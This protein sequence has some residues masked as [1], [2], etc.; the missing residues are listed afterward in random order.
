MKSIVPARILKVKGMEKTIQEDLLVMEEPLEIRLVYHKNGV[1]HHKSISVTLRTPGQE[2]E[3]ALGFLFTEGII[4]SAAQVK[5]ISPAIVRMKQA[6]DNAIVVE[7]ADEV[8]VNIRKLERHFYTASSC[9]VCGKASIEAV[10]VQG[11]YEL[12]ESQPLFSAAILHTLPEKLLRQQ[13]VFDCTGGLHGAALFDMDGKLVSAREDVGRHNALD[14]LIGAELLRA[15]L[16]L[17]NHGVLVSGRAGFE[18]VQKS[19]MAGIPIMA[20]VGAPSS[21]A[22]ELAEE[23]GMTLVGFLRNGQFNIYSHPERV[24]F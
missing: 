17:S 3:L 1:Y 16:P 7:L 21:L 9:G 5:S 20:A 10:R 2:E 22:V 23:A 6:K 4:A 12:A 8:N 14:K 24:F 18:L 13:S 15:S 11:Q 19:L